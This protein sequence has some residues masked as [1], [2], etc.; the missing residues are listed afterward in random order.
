MRQL[1]LLELRRG[2]S[3]PIAWGVGVIFILLLASS[4]D[5]DPA[6]QELWTALLL[7]LVPVAAIQASGILP[8]WRAGEGDWL[9]SRPVGRTTAL[10]GS[11]AG[12]TSAGLLWLA[13]GASLVELRTNA[14]SEGMRL[15]WSQDRAEVGRLE[16]GQG[17]RV[18][19]SAPP[20]RPGDRIRVRVRPTVGAAPTTNVR[21]AAARSGGGQEGTARVATRTWIE[22]PA[23]VG[24]GPL[25][26]QVDVVGEGAVAWLARDSVEL[27]T[28]A[29]G[30]SSLALWWR[31]SLLVALL[32]ALAVGASAWMRP[33]PAAGAALSIVPLGAVLGAPNAWPGVGLYSA[34]GVVG[35]GRIPS[36]G[37]PGLIFSALFITLVGIALARPGLASWRHRR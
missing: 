25:L 37:G 1:F 29:D 19:L 9:G 4:G 15:A 6:R 8:R 7:G 10:A 20:T 35:E 36:A 17:A 14:P 21:L 34:L 12:S 2:L 23:P 11:W 27:W 5:G 30:T 3:A 24:D 32:G 33:G 28:P 16:P 13:L 26:L 18:E 31:G 22:V